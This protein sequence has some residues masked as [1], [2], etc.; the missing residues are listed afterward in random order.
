MLPV[1][2]GEEATTRS[3]LLY[4]GT[5]V[6]VSLLLVPVAPMGWIYLLVAAGAGGWFVW[7]SWRVR[8]D[9]TRAM[10]LFTVSTVYLAILFGSV[11]GASPM[12]EIF[13]VGL[14]WVFPVVVVGMILW[15]AFKTGGSRS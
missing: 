14:V 15:R 11:V 6:L 12:I 13:T 5:M 4:A 10:K 2:R 9:P 3:I 7:E 1:V 8:M